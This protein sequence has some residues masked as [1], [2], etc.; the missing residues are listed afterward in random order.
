MLRQQTWVCAEL[1]SR[2]GKRVVH[3][4]FTT[5]RP[6]KMIPLD[7]T[8]KENIIGTFPEAARPYDA[9]ELVIAACLFAQIDNDGGEEADP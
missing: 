6:P 8:A 4:P 5:S 9:R 7:S 3:G 2:F 1:R